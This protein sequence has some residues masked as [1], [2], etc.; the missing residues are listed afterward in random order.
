MLP[1]IKDKQKNQFYG[2]SIGLVVTVSIMC[3]GKIS[4]CCLNSAVW[5]GFVIPAVLVSLNPD[6]PDI[7]LSDAWIYWTAPF[8]GAALSALTFNLF[9][10]AESKKVVMIN[11]S[12]SQVSVK[13]Y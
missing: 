6:S 8:I 5:I 3:I 7:D 12:V 4:G 11:V 1:P 10:G 9:F 2:I 13:N